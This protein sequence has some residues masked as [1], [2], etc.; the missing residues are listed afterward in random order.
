VRWLL[1][2]FGLLFALWGCVEKQS[3][4]EKRPELTGQIVVNVTQMKRDPILGTLTIEGKVKNFTNTTLQT[5]SLRFEFYDKNKQLVHTETR[6]VLVFERFR[7]ND[8]RA[9]REDFFSIPNEAR[10]VSVSVEDVVE[11][12]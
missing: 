2:A 11:A 8:V 3:T 7:P 9:F 10:T 4:A 1:V 5:V 6:Y 12:W